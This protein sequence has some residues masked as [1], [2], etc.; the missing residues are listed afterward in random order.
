[1]TDLKITNVHKVECAINYH[2]YD[3]LRF[4]KEKR[5]EKVEKIREY[6]QSEFYMQFVEGMLS[7]VR[8]IDAQIEVLSR[9]TKNLKG[10]VEFVEME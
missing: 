1:M 4:L 3:Q 10:N 6:V 9:L 5:T 8:V 7:D 2:V